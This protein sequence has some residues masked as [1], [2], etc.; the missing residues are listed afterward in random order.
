MFCA[1][2]LALGCADDEAH[3]PT[4]DGGSEGSVVDAGALDSGPLDSGSLDAGSLDAGSLDAMV[5]GSRSEACDLSACPDPAEI[6]QALGLREP[7]SC[8]VGN[9]CGVTAVEGWDSCRV[10]DVGATDD[11][12]LD[13]D[14][15]AVDGGVAIGC[16]RS[17]NTCGHLDEVLGCHRLLNYDWVSELTSC[18][19]PAE[20]IPD[21]PFMCKGDDVPCTYDRECCEHFAYSTQCST[22]MFADAGEKTCNTCPDC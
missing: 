22:F 14:L 7:V 21:G 12:C 18:D 9:R 5:D 20:E 17:D 3:V 6:A 1:M 8:C 13:A 10:I 2:A 15:G 16:C 4:E 19:G 11:D